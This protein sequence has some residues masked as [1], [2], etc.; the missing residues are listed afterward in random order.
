MM[1]VF[2]QLV[3]AMGTMASLSTMLT[4]CVCAGRFLH[5]FCT[6]VDPVLS[7]D[8]NHH[9]S[10][11]AHVGGNTSKLEDPLV[12][13]L[14]ADWNSSMFTKARFP[15]VLIQVGLRDTLLS[16]STMMFRKLT[17]AGF[18]CVKFSPWDVPCIPIVER[19]AG[20]AAA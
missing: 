9:G 8:R 1:C 5:A 16:A 17:A 13:R 12:S 10:A 11:L 20:R 2:A 4:A 18:P 15:A 19:Q 7:W 6:G 3:H 14:R